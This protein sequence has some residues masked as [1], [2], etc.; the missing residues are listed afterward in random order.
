M[1]FIYKFISKI[2]KLL[3]KKMKKILNSFD[4]II[5]NQIIKIISLY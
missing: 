4:K 1:I 2:Y 5:I 3:I